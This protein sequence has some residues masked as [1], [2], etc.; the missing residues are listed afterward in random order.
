MN[1]HFA[2]HPTPRLDNGANPAVTP[3]ADQSLE[4]YGMFTS[5]QQDVI[6]RYHSTMRVLSCLGSQ[7]HRLTQQQ[8]MD[9]QHAL[10]QDIGEPAA[11]KRG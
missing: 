11:G 8:L 6:R 4:M 3:N 9:T 2:S 7:R 5:D 1:L 10:L